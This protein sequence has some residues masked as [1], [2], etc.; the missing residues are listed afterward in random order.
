[1]GGDSAAVAGGRLAARDQRDSFGDCK[2]D[3]PD[4]LVFG[5]RLDNAVGQTGSSQ[6]LECTGQHPRVM[7]VDAPLAHVEAGALRRDDALDRLFLGSRDGR[8]FLVPLLRVSQPTADAGAQRERECHY[9]HRVPGCE[10]RV[11]PWVN[12]GLQPLLVGDRV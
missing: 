9:V 12:R 5:L 2:V 3:Q 8:H 11:L 7:G 6:Y 4:D 1:V 10:Q